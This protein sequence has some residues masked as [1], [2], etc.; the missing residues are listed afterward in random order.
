MYYRD[1]NFIPD[2]DVWTRNNMDKGLI[3]LTSVPLSNV[4]DLRCCPF[5]TYMELNL[6]HQWVR[7]PSDYSNENPKDYPAFKQI[8]DQVK[9]QIST[10]GI[11]SNAKPLA[12]EALRRN[13]KAFYN[14][15][16]LHEDQLNL[17]QK[18]RIDSI[19]FKRHDAQTNFT[20]EDVNYSLSLDGKNLNING[21]GHKQITVP[22]VN[23]Y[24]F[25]NVSVDAE[26]PRY[27]QALFHIFSVRPDIMDYLVNE[28]KDTRF[29]GEKPLG[30]F[31]DKHAEVIDLWL[32][33]RCDDSE[34]IR[35]AMRT[36]AGHDTFREKKGN[37]EDLV[38]AA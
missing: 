5:G 4:A 6:N 38:L 27:G 17:D 35:W 7:V 28:F 13:E 18:A 12:A 15:N 16:D 10:N 31:I 29:V 9:H 26:K 32:N 37:I 25:L 1:A 11:F 23:P 14:V 19:P 8:F 22:G 33:R 21:S 34:K 3:K 30:Y 2:K 24:F 20:L 36:I